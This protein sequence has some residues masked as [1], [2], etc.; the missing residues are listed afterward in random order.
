MEGRRG[1]E[2]WVG[3]SCFGHSTVTADSVRANN[4]FF[5]V[6]QQHPPCEWRL[7]VNVHTL[8]RGL[9]EAKKYNTVRASE[10]GTAWSRS[11]SLHRL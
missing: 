7:P 4:N 6:V 9:S 11:T 3:H 2:G 5:S 1:E 8:Q 10:T